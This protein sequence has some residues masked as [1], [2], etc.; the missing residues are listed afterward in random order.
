[1]YPEYDQ[2]HI[3]QE[4]KQRYNRRFFLATHGGGL[5]LALVIAWVIPM[6]TSIAILTML[7]VIIAI[8]VFIML[9]PHAIYVGYH[10]YQYWL[11]HKVDQQLRPEQW[12]DDPTG[13]KQKRYAGDELTGG[14]FQLTDD[15]ELE[16][17]LPSTTLQDRSYSSESD[18]REPKTKLSKKEKKATQKLRKQEKSRREIDLDLDIDLDFDVKK[19]F[20]KIKD[21][22]D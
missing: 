2:E 3:R 5:L 4:I 12:E 6:L 1:M 18:Y 10:E 17:V 15:G 7:F 22:I 16:E 19:L 14:R 21:I 9:I 13:Q 8:L 11:D 20:K